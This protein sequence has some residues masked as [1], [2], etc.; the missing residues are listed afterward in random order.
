MNTQDRITLTAPEALELARAAFAMAG[1]RDEVAALMARIFTEAELDGI[2]SHGLARVPGVCGH[3]ASGRVAGAAVPVV[4][5]PAPAMVLAD[6]RGGFPQPAFQAAFE[7]TLSAVRACGIATLVVTDCFAADVMGWHTERFAEAGYLAIGC[8]NVPAAIAPLGGNRPVLGT[9]PITCAIPRAGQPPIVIDQASSVIAKSE[10]VERAAAGEAL[11]PGWAVDSEGA[12][13]LDAKAAL[14]GA[15]LPAGG[16]KGFGIALMVEALTAFLAG[17]QTSLQAP[18][19]AKA[20]APAPRLSQSYIVLD[21]A[22]IAGPD[23]MDSVEGLVTAIDA[24]PGA[25]LP[26]SRRIEA[27]RRLAETGVTLPATLVVKLKEIA[28]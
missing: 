14:A 28:G 6:A 2:A 24:Q 5:R 19:L 25:R 7:D 13:T 3:V 8:A 21:P 15:M 22:R 16:Y 9:N 23:W 4:T 18:P 20:D 17:S 26:G 10:I 1:C 12:P 27:R 11:E